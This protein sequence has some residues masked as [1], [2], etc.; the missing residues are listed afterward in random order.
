MKTVAYLS[1]RLGAMTWAPILEGADRDRALAAIDEIGEALRRRPP[2]SL[3]LAGGLAGAALFFAH[4]GLARDDHDDWDHAW[5]LLDQAIGGLAEAALP[6][7]LFGGFSGIAWALAHV[8]GLGDDDGEGE[9][10]VDDVGEFEEVDQIV[11]RLLDV[12]SWLGDY[13]LVSGLTGLMVYALARLPDAAGAALGDRLV[14]LV[15]LAAESVDGATRWPTRVELLPPWQAELAPRGYYNAGVAHGIPGLIAALAQ[16]AGADRRAARARAL[17]DGGVAWIDS[18]AGSTAAPSWIAI[19]GEPSAARTAWCYGDLGVAGALM[20]A[21]RA[22]GD[23]ALADRALAIGRRAAAVP[24]ERTGVV[25]PGLCHGAVGNAHVFNRLWQ[26]T[27]DPELLA[28]ARRC[29][30]RGLDLLVSGSFFGGV[31]SYNPEAGELIASPGFLE[32]AT[33][34]GLGLLAATSDHEPSWDQ[35][36]LLSPVRPKID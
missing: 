30:Q 35:I 6:V 18:V 2:E 11:G 20:C 16:S 1:G 7:G 12:E 4:R 19:G 29:Y 21:S 26:A 22:L 10:D 8:G 24:L 23:G 25:D 17:V 27:G 36:L 3:D 32:G 14:E 34:V 28:A 33:G 31:G 5:A 13:D 9:D 15:D